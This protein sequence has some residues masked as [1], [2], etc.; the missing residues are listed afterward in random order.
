MWAWL[1]R[2]GG[3][4][5]VALLGKEVWDRF[6]G[7]PKL[8][9]YRVYTVREAARILRCTP[10]AVR[11]E[12]AQGRLSAKWVGDDYRILG[13]AL[14]AYFKEQQ[15]KQVRHIVIRD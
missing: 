7:T 9:R 3:A 12:I 11:R 14:V 1:Q 6:A 5:V 10:D 2:L 15:E 8:E 13:E 4:A